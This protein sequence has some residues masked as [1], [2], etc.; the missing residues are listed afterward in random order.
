[1]AHVTVIIP[2]QDNESTIGA[3]IQSALDQTAANVAVIV[4][5]NRSDKGTLATINQYVERAPERVLLITEAGAGF[6]LMR[7]IGIERAQGEWVVILDAGDTLYPDA[8]AAWLDYAEQHPEHSVIY[9]GWLDGEAE[10]LPHTW[11]D[12]P[13]EGNILDTLV[14]SYDGIMQP[15]LIKK[16]AIQAAGGF[17][18]PDVEREGDAGWIHLL[19][20]FRLLLNGASFG[21]V[22]R[23]LL[24]TLRKFHMESLEPLGVAN[25]R[26][27][28]YRWALEKDP[29]RMVAA[30]DRVNE[31]R[32]AQLK[33]AFAAL[34][35]RNAD[36]QNLLNEIEKARAYQTGLE[37]TLQQLQ[38]A[39][40]GGTDPQVQMLLAEIEK[41]RN[42]Q[43]WQ[44]QTIGTLR[45][46][47]FDLEKSLDDAKQRI[48]RDSNRPQQISALIDHIETLEAELAA[49]RATTSTDAEARQRELYEK[50]QDAQREL[51]E[52]TASPAFRLLGRRTP[53]K[54]TKP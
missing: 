23:V 5:D 26:L 31:I 36:M 14:R 48:Q 32:R 44:D 21:Y 33:D 41:A 1:M 28:V 2:S 6:G 53:R 11:T 34:R 17:S 4:V 18:H 3:S 19:G 13:L 20:Y 22:P 25:Q 24:R 27:A 39:Q 51:D 50:W 42:Y 54:E 43:A 38:H 30:I 37:T 45:Q 9:S 46:Q 8:V 35:A 47:V 16:A 49:Y 29:A 7:D 40:N 15:A 52:I 10:N 12:D